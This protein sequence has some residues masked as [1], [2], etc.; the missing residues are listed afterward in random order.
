MAVS[1][2]ALER[3]RDLIGE[4]RLLKQ[5][6]D[7]L[8]VELAQ[9]H[10]MRDT[11]PVTGFWGRGAFNGKL[12]QSLA[13]LAAGGGPLGLIVL[14]LKNYKSIV[15]TLHGDDADAALRA[16]AERAARAAGERSTL[17]RLS[18]EEFAILV[19]DA[20]ERLLKSVMH[21]CG[22]RL[23]VPF[24][25]AGKYVAFKAAIGGALAPL[26]ANSADDLQKAAAFA[27]DG[28]RDGDSVW[29]LYD[30]RM[31]A[32]REERQ[33]LTHDLRAA[34]SADCVESWFQPIVDAQTGKWRS[35]EVLARWRHPT[36]GF[37]SP[38]KFIPMAWDI[39]AGE[40]IQRRLL[41]RA[42]Q[43][44]LPWIDAGQIDSISFNFSPAELLKAD[45]QDELFRRLE[46]LKFPASALVVEMTETDLVES[47]GAA[48]AVL[49]RLRGFGVGIALDDFGTGYSNLRSLIG[50]PISKL[51]LDK[52]LIDDIDRDKRVST[53]AHSIITWAESMGVATVAEGVEDAEQA[54]LL[55]SF[56]VTM[57]QG[58]FYGKPMP[59]SDVA[60]AQALAA[61]G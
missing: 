10:A 1:A 58:Y 50:L 24:N 28:E 25:V 19:P 5:K 3:Q 60:A 43:S 17:A 11:D 39:G 9:L 41:I 13:E 48:H 23:A 33:S 16:L 46:R 61:A 21:A 4:N 38:A 32:T 44:A 7:A 53:L 51:K 22:T 45:F 26:H 6:I 52:S 59:A 15:E 18:S 20:D 30:D 31:R 55:R 49:S 34:I 36:H 42:C 14:S 57:I 29:A 37:I 35:L 12:A 54:R 27:R 2:S 56:G 40:A 47:I 8:R